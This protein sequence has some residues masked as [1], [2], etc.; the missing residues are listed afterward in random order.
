VGDVSRPEKRDSRWVDGLWPK[1]CPVIREADSDGGDFPQ[2]SRGSSLV[3]RPRMAPSD[4]TVAPWES[5]QGDSKVWSRSDVKWL[6]SQSRRVS[7]TWWPRPRLGDIPGRLR[8][9]CS[10]GL[11][12]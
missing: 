3:G 8:A 9:A 2:P 6:P 5:V 12:R 7:L 10:H 4:L 11:G 1:I